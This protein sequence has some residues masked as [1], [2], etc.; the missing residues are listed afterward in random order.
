LPSLNLVLEPWENLLV[1]FAAAKV[2]ARPGLDALTPGGAVDA[3]PPGLSLTTGNPFLDPIRSNNY[4]ISLEWYPYEDALFSVAFFRKEIGSFVQRLQQTLP[5]SATGFPLSL[6][7]AS[8]TPADLFVV[9]SQVNTRG[10]DLTGFEVTLQTP[11]TFLKG[12]F[13]GLGGLVN[14]TEIESSLNYITNATTGATVTQ[15]LVGQSPRSAS[16]T[17]YYER[18]PFE[19]R[20]SGT[21]RDEYLTLVPAASGNDVEGKASQLN[22]DFSMSYNIND[23]LTFSFEGVNLTDQYD[24]RWISSQR[25][26]SNNYEHTGR[27]FVFGVQYKY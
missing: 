19:A 6:L 10:G 1:R 3:Q 14:Y 26:N 15:P 17:L 7:P 4:D 25:K 20:V 13:E 23:R 22:V 21:Y 18:G 12:P 2:M 5:Y 24:E 9:T 27:E 11:F 8:V 16:T